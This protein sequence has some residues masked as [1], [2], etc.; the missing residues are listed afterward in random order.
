[1]AALTGASSA[2]RTAALSNMSQRVQRFIEEEMEFLGDQVRAEAPAAQ[3]RILRVLHDLAQ[4]GQVDW[5]HGEADSRVGPER[6]ERMDRA[7]VAIDY[8]RQPLEG[9]SPEQVA[10]MWQ[11]VAAQATQHGI[12]SLAYEAAEAAEPLVTEGL[13]LTLDGTEPALIED[14]LRTRLECVLLPRM[15]AAA[16][17][18]AQA[19]AGVRAAESPVLVLHRLCA[20]FCTFGEETDA[21]A[22]LDPRISTDELAGRLRAQPFASLDNAARAVLLAHVGC[23]ARSQGLAS[24]AALVDATDDEMLRLALG[25][26]A[27]EVDASELAQTLERHSSERLRQARARW[28]MCITGVRMMQ[29]GE[30]PEAIHGGV[31]RAGQEALQTTPH[32]GEAWSTSPT[33]LTR[34]GG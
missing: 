4:Q 31:L 11:Q 13:Q 14:L 25:L 34:A 18:V 32:T 17:M 23:L 28:V 8:L 10:E 12:L 5:P 19:A 3:R 30:R 1:V 20:R 2:A 33:G 7:R 6:A 16:A 9:Q 26:L 22:H 27:R 29:D 15:V 24:L 21:A